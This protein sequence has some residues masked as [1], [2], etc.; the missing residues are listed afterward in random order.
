MGGLGSAEERAAAGLNP[1]PGLDIALE[2]VA[3]MPAS[4][5]E[6]VRSSSD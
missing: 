1:V 6:I 2:D 4:D 5:T 3:T